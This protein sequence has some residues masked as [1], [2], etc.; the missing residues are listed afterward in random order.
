MNKPLRHFTSG[1]R[2]A[3]PRLKRLERETELALARAWREE[4][5]VAARNRLVEA[6]IPLAV[7]MAARFMKRPADTDPDLVQHAHLGLL[8]AADRFDPAL[9]WRFSTYAAWWVRAELQDYRM[10]NRS[11]VRRTNSQRTRWLFNNLAKAERSVPQEDGESP[12]ER[13]RRIA[14]ALG[15]S[16]AEF[17]G[18]REEVMGSDCSLNVRMAEGDGDEWIEMLDDPEGDVE[19]QVMR[20]RDQRR[21]YEALARHLNTLPERERDI[22]IATHLQDPPATLDVLGAEYGISKERVRQ[23]RER[24]IGRL[25]KA[26]AG[27]YPP[28]ERPF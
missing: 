21:F 14:E 6:Y 13:D 18:L 12:G 2:K 20:R 17:E 1:E 4:G 7:S 27:T 26:M 15:L 11:L 3:A 8:K 24:A 25:R 5:D 10:A 22:V 28:E 19:A 9:G 16:A 23:L